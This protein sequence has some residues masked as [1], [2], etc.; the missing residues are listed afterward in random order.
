MG[1]FDNAVLRKIFGPKGRE[2]KRERRK[3]YKE[4]LRDLYSSPNMSWM[5]K[6]R[7]KR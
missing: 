4:I 2:V 3:L 6:S 7:R 5:I 1:E